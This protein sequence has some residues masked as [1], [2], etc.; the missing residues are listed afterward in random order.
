MCIKRIT[1]LILIL[2]ILSACKSKPEIYSKSEWTHIYKTISLE[3]PEG[4][5]NSMDGLTPRL[6]PVII[7]D[8]IYVNYCIV[9]PIYNNDDVIIGSNF[10]NILY[11]YDI[12]G[13]VIDIID[14][15]ID[16]R[17]II[18]PSNNN[19]VYFSDYTIITK[20]TYSGMVL[21]ELPFDKMN[22]N[23]F[24]IYIDYETDH[25]YIQQNYELFVI[26]NI[27]G[28]TVQRLTSDIYPEITK[29]SDGKIIAKTYSMNFGPNESR[30]KF[31]ELDIENNKLVDYEIPK[32]PNVFTTDTIREMEPYLSENDSSEYDIYYKTT[33][34]VYG[35]KE[36]EENVELLLNWLNSD[37][38]Y[39]QCTILS[40]ITPDLFLCRLPYNTYLYEIAL[41][42]R[43][44]DDEVVPKTII[45]LATTESFRFKPL[46]PIIVMFNKQ[47][48][49]YR[50]LIEDYSTYNTDE[51]WNRGT[52]LFNLDIAAG[53]VHDLV[54]CD[55][56]DIYANK[57]MFVD[58]YDYMSGDNL[59]GIL[60]SKYEMNSHLYALPCSFNIITLTG[61]PSIVGIKES[62]TLD[63]L[64]EINSKLPPETKLFA[65]FNGNNVFY[66]TLQAGV[67]D[68]IDFEKGTC[69]FI[70]SDFIMLLEFT[71]T[72]PNEVDGY[73]GYIEKI[74][75]DEAYIYEF[76]INNLKSF[77][78]LKFAYGDYDY[79][80]KGFPIQ[81]GNGTVLNCSSF[82]S[83]HS[84]SPNKQGAWE[85]IKFLLTD[86]MQTYKDDSIP[87]TNSGLLK[88]FDRYSQ[89]YFY[90]ITG[91]SADG[92]P[93]LSIREVGE[94]YNETR[95]ELTEED[96]AKII[97]FFNTTNV[98]P[99]YDGTILEII[100]EE[101][102]SFFADAITAQKC[103]EYIQNRVTTYLNEQK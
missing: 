46:I 3:Q 23:V 2:I 65:T 51:D 66:C 40:I 36:G 100:L 53:A 45:T 76:N 64:I 88:I 17:G 32:I 41:L 73:F 20:L 94:L 57:G 4:Y 86:E 54:F 44:P 19:T 5:K 29:A 8:K 70:G 60:R 6:S 55:F 78:D 71:K 68:F 59:L 48:D 67:S 33:Y 25:M 75:N 52:T 77:I 47:S 21:W 74:R 96:K 34:G 24:I 49:D 7:D 14:L 90:P 62:L 38:I 69:D 16:K 26:S 91:Y 35:Y 12:N 87:V 31:Y 27:T 79:V 1:S 15:E 42:K 72:L 37:I 28:E 97:R 84:K 82:L 10:S 39:N 63:E 83:I 56:P 18:I 92:T 85:F 43:I 30:F 80:I 101:V 93:N 98:P 50:V 99:K 58:L 13:E 95:I 81:N 89:R 102:N 103:A 11:I 61:K 9:A 22:G